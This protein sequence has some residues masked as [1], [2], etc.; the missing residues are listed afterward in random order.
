MGA[1]SP[2][3]GPRECI[4]MGCNACCMAGFCTATAHRH[5]SPETKQSNSPNKA[6][7]ECVLAHNPGIS[8]LSECTTQD[9]HDGSGD[10]TGRHQGV[11]TAT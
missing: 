3:I 5:R 11:R 2:P 8:Q 7:R 1:L 6:N 9:H 4:E 10:T